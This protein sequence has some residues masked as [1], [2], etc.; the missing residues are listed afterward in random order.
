MPLCWKTTLLPHLRPRL[1]TA[2][3]WPGGNAGLRGDKGEHRAAQRFS[4]TNPTVD[5]DLVESLGDQPNVPPMSS[6]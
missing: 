3:N 6:P 5:L 4:T 2:P 1:Q